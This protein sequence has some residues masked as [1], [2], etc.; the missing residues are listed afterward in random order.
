MTRAILPLPPRRPRTPHIETLQGARLGNEDRAHSP[1]AGVLCVHDGHGGEAA[2]QRL[3]EVLDTEVHWASAL[4]GPHAPELVLQFLI[5]AYAHAARALK[6]EPS[7]AVSITALCTP[8]GL[9]FGWV[10]DC[11]GCALQAAGTGV[12]SALGLLETDDAVLQLLVD[13][14]PLPRVPH[15]VR[16][17]IE[18]V[19]HSLLA[20][21]PP[22]VQLA[23]ASVCL[24]PLDEAKES[25]VALSTAR[26]AFLNAGAQK[27]WVLAQQHHSNRKPETPLHADLVFLR[28]GETQLF[29]DARIEDCTQPTR[30]LGDAGA[31][32][33]PLPFAQTLFAPALAE[34]VLLASD[35]PFANGAFANL[36]ALAHCIQD[37]LGFVRA[38]FY[39][40][41]QEFTER[42]RLAGLLA[43]T[44]EALAASSATWD[45]FLRFVDR[46]HMPLLHH[47]RLSA[48]YVHGASEELVRWRVAAHEASHWL[49]MH[50]HRKPCTR[51]GDCRL[52]AG[53][54]ARLALL[55]GSTDNITLLLWC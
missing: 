50:S 32:Q 21:P 42:M 33:R 51:G 44:Q 1:H 38:Q 20:H 39:R 5:D 9:F 6:D 10:G 35:G 19:P 37:P 28:L 40:A 3:V 13:A 14:A 12:Q 45:D 49:H 23:D 25:F 36:D 2:V 22:F 46:H 43:G 48:T 30:A 52:H 55:M 17:P 41:G 31:P 24:P 47:D 15:V 8:Q 27:E 29:L 16:R 18:T 11:Q 7:G 54:A 34:M 26:A 53:V 4:E